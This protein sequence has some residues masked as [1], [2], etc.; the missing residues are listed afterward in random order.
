MCIG[1]VALKIGCIAKGPNLY[2]HIQIPGQLSQYLDIKFGHVEHV[3]M[4]VTSDL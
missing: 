1:V 3:K 2:K 4:K